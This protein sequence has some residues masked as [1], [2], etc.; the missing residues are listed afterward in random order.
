MTQSVA[1]A[2]GGQR[3]GAEMVVRAITDISDRTSE[4]RHSVEQLSGSARKL[5]DQ[6]RDLEELVSRFKVA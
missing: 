1:T 6:A 4:N 5:S 3:R 2:T